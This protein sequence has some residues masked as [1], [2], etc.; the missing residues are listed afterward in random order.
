MAP[1]PGKYCRLVLCEKIALIT[2]MKVE[3]PSKSSGAKG[4]SKTGAKK[5]A[6]DTSFSGLIEDTPE[7]ES[8]KST[9]GTMSIQG[10]DALLSLQEADDGTSPEAR[11]KAKERG[12]ALLD[13]LDKLRVGLL[14]GEVPIM[15]L[16][17]LSRMIEN[18]RDTIA[19]P[20]LTEILNE[21]DLR[22]QVE[23]AKFSQRS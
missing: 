12:N 22:V 15:A 9:A 19:D 3:G 1:S 11:R 5:G 8:A 2:E 10:I 4:V 20:Q 21:I 23:L 13:Q 18:H 7:L 6:G 17:N 16:D 14:V